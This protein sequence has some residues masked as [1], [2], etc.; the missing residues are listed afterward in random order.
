VQDSDPKEAALLSNA[1]VEGL[2]K[3]TG[4][5]ALTESSQRRLFF[6]KEMQSQKRSLSDAEEALK[7][8]EERTGVLQVSSQVDSMIRSMAQLRA[9]I[10]SREVALA[11]LRNG[12]TAQNPEVVRQESEL[13]AMR[14]QLQSLEASNKATEP[15][16]PMIP[17]SQVPKAGLQYVRALRDLQYNETLF[18]LLSKQYEIARIDEAKDAPL[19]QV[20][21]SAIPPERKSWPPRMVFSLLGAMAAGLLACLIAMLQ[22]PLLNPQEAR[23][24][25]LLR[26]RL[27]GWRRGHA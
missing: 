7:N 1:Y 16:D 14:S 12:A 4:R 25:R 15:G 6:E 3:Q 17:T 24:L 2:Y 5:L 20:V 8:T 26:E 22:S 21:D 19:I 23:K 11:S 9:E 10:A 27:F 18:E 13:A